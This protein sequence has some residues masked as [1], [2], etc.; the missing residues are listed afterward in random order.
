M[1]LGTEESG[2]HFGEPQVIPLV[3]LG[4][5]IFNTGR[6]LATSGNLS[7]E[8]TMVNYVHENTPPAQR[9]IGC[10][11]EF[12]ISAY[13]PRIGFGRQKFWFRLSF[14]YN[15]NDV[16]NVAINL[17]EDKSS[18]MIESEFS[19]RFVGQ[20]Y[21]VQRDPV[22]EVLFKIS[23]RWDP[24]GRGVDSFWGELNVR[25]DGRVRLWVKSE[26]GWVRDEPFIL[27]T[28]ICRIVAPSL[29]PAPLPSTTAF[30]DVF[31]SPPGSD[32]IRPGDEQKIV[33]WY[34]R[35]P[36]DVQR[37][38]QAGELSITLEGHAST[39]QPGPA[40]REL[41]R[42]RGLRVQRILQDIAGSNVRFQVFAFGEYRAGTPDEVEDPSKRRVR[43]SITYA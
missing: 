28:S 40:N 39:T 34:N 21:S 1:Y 17:L 5:S 2:S 38:V 7:Y 23:G 24:V 19:I 12:L 31:F 10:N 32:M 26:Q 36:P 13:H 30:W 33:Q 9:F 29:P 15:G 18:R 11:R 14:E 27:L 16:R 6:T 42:R 4:L 41:S 43:I 22:A 35:L 8:A 37:R 20:P 25:A 3:G